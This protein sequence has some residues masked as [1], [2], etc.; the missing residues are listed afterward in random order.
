MFVTLLEHTF[1]IVFYCVRK[2]LTMKIKQKKA[3]YI[4]VRILFLEPSGIGTW[5]LLLT[6]LLRCPNMIV[7][8]VLKVRN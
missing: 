6:D 2:K 7:G 4:G 3:S 8:S 5:Y 1:G